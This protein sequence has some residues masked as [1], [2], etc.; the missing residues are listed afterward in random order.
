M[1]IPGIHKDLL[2]AKQRVYDICGFN[3]THIKAEEESAD[4]GACTFR[5]N[6]NLIAFRAA[7]F[8]PTKTGQF[9]TVWKRSKEGPIRPFDS[10]DPIDFVVISTR[11]KERNGQFIFSRMVLCDKGIMTHNGK[12]GKRGMR[13]YPPWDQASSKQAANTQNWQADYFI[14]MTDDKRIDID[15]AKKLLGALN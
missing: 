8:T 15:R 14:E 7:K 11:N 3:C 1:T 10:S 9:V 13:V 2:Y 4:Y 5:L 6:G 12:E